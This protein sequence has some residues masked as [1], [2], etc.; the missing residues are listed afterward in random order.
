MK[1]VRI[2]RERDNDIILP[3]GDKSASRHHCQIIQENDGTY[4]LVD[5]GSTN[6]TY[7]NGVQ[8]HGQVKLNRNDIVRAGNQTLPWQTYFTNDGGCGGTQ[9]GPD[10]GDYP[11]PMPPMAKPDNY[12]VWAILEII[13]CSILCGIFATVNASK[14]D[15]LWSAGDYAGATEAARK[16]K[17]W[18]W[19]G[20]GLG[21]VRIIVTICLELLVGVL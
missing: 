18:F 10:G 15:S 20:F 2:G 12:L 11:P 6:G 1:I 16:A 5:V 4:T 13:F 3:A 9:I 21:L 8:R 17:T 7:V 19:W 14:V